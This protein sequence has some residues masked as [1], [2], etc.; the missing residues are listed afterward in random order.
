MPAWALPAISLGLGA[1][2]MLNKPKA[3]PA[4]DPSVAIRAQGDE[5]RKAAR[6]TGR[7]NSIGMSRGPF[8]G[9]YSRRWNPDSGWTIRHRAGGMAERLAADGVG[10]L[11][12]AA[13]AA[14]ASSNDFDTNYD[15]VAKGIGMGGGPEGVTGALFRRLSEQNYDDQKRRDSMYAA[16][17]L[18]GST[19]QDMGEKDARVREQEAYTSA[20]LAG[21]QEHSRLL[22]EAR[23][24]GDYR[25]RGISMGHGIGMANLGA[26]QSLAASTPTS[27]PGIQVAPVNATGAH[28]AADQSNL[29]RY[30]TKTNSWNELTGS[31]LSLGFNQAHKI[32]WLGGNGSGGMKM[33]NYQWGRH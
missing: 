16:R 22:G 4:V 2:N 26:A 30:Q 7:Y 14:G 18:T 27:A 29:Q 31:L 3:P 25:R 1:M 21:G 11:T 12:G 23:A 5:N 19:L 17:G 6:L 33:G 10:A 24:L 8:G 28:A 9:S 13:G 15:Y 32:P 20:I